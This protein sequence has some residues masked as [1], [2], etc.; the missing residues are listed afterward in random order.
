MQLEKILISKNKNFA[1]AKNFLI[2]SL[3]CFIGAAALNIFIVPLNLYSGGILG[4]A[5]LIRSVVISVFNLQGPT[6]FDFAGIIYFLI[7]IPLLYLAWKGFGRFLFIRTIIMTV[8]FTFFLSIVPVPRTKVIDDILTSCIVGGLLA[9]AGSGLTLYSG[10]TA[11]GG[12]ILGL[13]FTKKYDNFSVGKITI[14]INIVVFGICLF[15]YNFQTVIYSMLFN[16]FSAFAV[17]KIHAQNINV[18]IVIFTKKEGIPKS[19]M[20]QLGRGVTNW[21]GSGAYT[22]EHTFVHS[23]VINKFEVPILKKLV[24]E[25]DPHAFIIYNEGTLVTGN[26]EKRL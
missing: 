11:G 12:D 17:D 9:G 5:Q 4:L 23:T 2:A 15:L 26:F 22:G 14:L 21:D 3:G 1:L 13:Y 16:T 6:T 18:W 19:I 20:S 8:L 10:Y 7:N 25:I 24:K